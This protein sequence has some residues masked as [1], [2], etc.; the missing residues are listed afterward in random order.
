M[1]EFPID[2]QNVLLCDE[3]VTLYDKTE[4]KRVVVAQGRLTLTQ[5]ALSVGD[6]QMST[7]E[8]YGGC[9]QDG[10]KFSFNVGNRSYI[11]IGNERFNGLKY[12]LFFNRVCPQIAEKG[13]DKYYGLYLDPSC[14]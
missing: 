12:V 10:T 7:A 2:A 9:A 5:S 6:W 3:N 4:Q 8:I 13:G 14:R 11:V 1:R